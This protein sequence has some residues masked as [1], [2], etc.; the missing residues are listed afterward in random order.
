MSDF[1]AHLRAAL[2]ARPVAQVSR[3]T[4]ISESLLRKYLSGA[5]EPTLGKIVTLQHYL[6]V[7]FDELLSGRK[8]FDFGRGVA[9]FVSEDSTRAYLQNPHEEL[10]AI[11][12]LE[13]A[14]SAGPGSMIEADSAFHV[15][16]YVRE[17][18]RREIGTNLAALRLARVR[19]R[20]MEPRLQDRDRVFIDTSLREPREGGVYVFRQGEDFR[21]KRVVSRDDEGVTVASDNAEAY[22]P[23]L[24]RAVDIASGDVAF[25]G[26]VVFGERGFRV[27]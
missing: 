16:H 10:V 25:I 15:V 13:G 1:P 22:P 26:A 19:G 27:R 9:A 8:S 24:L 14:V 3:D 6:G 20:S 23:E 18:V 4:G 17:W 7:P 5:S 21:L 11:Q 12:M 2:A